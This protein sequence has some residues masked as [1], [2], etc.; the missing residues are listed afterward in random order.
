VS[1]RFTETNIAGLPESNFVVADL[2]VNNEFAG[3]RG[4]AGLQLTNV[5]DR[6]FAAVIEGISVDR[7]APY[8]RAI[9]SLRWRLW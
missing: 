4:L 6:E 8:R 9:A 3:K 2:E 7:I 5:F 1:Q